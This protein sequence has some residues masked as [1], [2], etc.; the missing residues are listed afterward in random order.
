M[1]STGRQQKMI[2]SLHSSTT[3]VR[4]VYLLIVTVVA[5]SREHFPF[6]ALR[7]T[8]E[9]RLLKSRFSRISRF[10]KLAKIPCW[11]FAA[12]LNGVLYR[13]HHGRKSNNV[14]PKDIG[15]A[16]THV[17][18]FRSNSVASPRIRRSRSTPLKKY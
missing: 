18:T 17:G 4:A 8:I 16:T 7:L 15:P 5:R 10:L 2:R 12:C 3:L 1:G 11:C 6:G 9:T 14:P 13:R